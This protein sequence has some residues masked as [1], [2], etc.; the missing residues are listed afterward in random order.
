IM[1]KFKRKD[2]VTVLQYV[3]DLLVAGAEQSDVEEETV[4]LLNYLGQQ[5]LR[6]SRSKVQH[7]EKEV[8]YLG[9]LISG[10]S[11][12]LSPERTAGIVKLPVPKTVREVRQLL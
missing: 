7:V 2:T 8:K 5:G 12:R 9:H 11:Q 10:G 1:E 6:V 3:D 4:K